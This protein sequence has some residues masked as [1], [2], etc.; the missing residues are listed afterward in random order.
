MLITASLFKHN[1]LG[2][3]NVTMWDNAVTTVIKEILPR[4]KGNQ[5][6]MV[7]KLAYLYGIIVIKHLVAMEDTHCN[8]F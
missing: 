5:L 7:A 3:N 2:Y 1:L 6:I 8:A 4:W